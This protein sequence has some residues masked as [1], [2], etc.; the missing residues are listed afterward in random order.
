MSRARVLA[1]ALLLAAPLL[2]CAS[3]HA[4]AR[5]PSAQAV[6]EKGQDVGSSARESLL[7]QLARQTGLD[8]AE[9]ASGLSG[10]AESGYFLERDGEITALGVPGLSAPPK[11]DETA[12]A[13][14]NQQ[15]QAW[16]S[17]L[18]GRF[19]LAGRME[20]F[21]S[22]NVSMPGM[23]PTF[24]RTTPVSKVS[25]V[26]DCAAI[27][28]GVGIHC[29]INATW[30]VVEPMGKNAFAE[31][32]RPP[33]PSE[34]VGVFHPAVMVLGFNP[35]TAEIRASMVTDDSMAHTWAGRVEADTLTARR[36]GACMALRDLARANPPPCFQPLEIIAEPGS[37]TITM[38][39]RA[40][41]VTVRMTMQR[42]PAARAQKPMKT[43]K[44]Q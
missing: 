25:G 29:I 40:M 39:Q 21:A 22:V 5:G 32:L 10:T 41:G 36:T 30:S 24:V 2:P 17:R 37:N 35:D 43:K 20:S 42:D 15:Q 8:Q 19:R 11:L 18:V 14:K 26:A 16:L 23:A 44:F 7:D 28:A 6:Q 13:N 4:Q 33:P 1:L 12:R 38:V 9:L 31:M 3:A 27:G 34:R